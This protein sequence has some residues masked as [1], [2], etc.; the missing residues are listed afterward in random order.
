MLALLNYYSLMPSEKTSGAYT[1]IFQKYNVEVGSS[2][3]NI[4]QSTKDFYFK[5]F[6]VCNIFMHSNNDK[7]SYDLCCIIRLFFKLIY[8]KNFTGMREVLQ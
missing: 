6:K 8:R 7:M 5:E 4:P 2:W 1:K 3:K